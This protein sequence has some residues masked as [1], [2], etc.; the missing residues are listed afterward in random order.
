MLL[1][2]TS[3]ARHTTPRTPRS[4]AQVLISEQP[5]PLAALS[6]QPLPVLVLLGGIA[7]NALLFPALWLYS[8]ARAGGGAGKAKRA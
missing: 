8:E 7:A 5:F 4:V 1:R 3:R 6:A 2:P